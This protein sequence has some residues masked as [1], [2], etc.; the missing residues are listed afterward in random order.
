MSRTLQPPSKSGLDIPAKISEFLVNALESHD[1]G[2]EKGEGEKER[3]LA[4]R[5]QL[6]RK[7]TQGWRR[8]CQ[9][10][11]HTVTSVWK[12]EEKEE[13]RGGKWAGGCLT[14]IT[15]TRHSMTHAAV[16][17]LYLLYGR[18]GLSQAL[19]V[20]TCGI[21]EYSLVAISS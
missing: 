11:P 20:L 1:E 13:E 21:T 6:S 3:R 5:S 15:N 18:A 19:V 16:R 17:I 7:E 2:M 12:R 14:G 4:E 10:L 8:E 9:A